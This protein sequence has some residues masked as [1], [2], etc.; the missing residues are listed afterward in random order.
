MISAVAGTFNI[1]HEGHKAMLDRA[2]QLGD[3]VYIG[4]TS[5]RMASSSRDRLNTY[6]I[7]EKAVKEYAASKKKPFSVFTIDDIYGPD[8]MMDHVDVLVV[9]EETLANGKKVVRKASEK[10][11]KMELSVVSIVQ[12]SDGGKLSS[13]DIMNGSCSRNG[14]AEAIDIAVG[15]TNPV[16][17]EAVRNVME[18]IFG[19]VRIFAYDVP[20]G[21][22]EQP[23]GDQTQKGAKNRARAALHDHTLSVG[24]EAGVFEMFD[25]LYDFQYCAILD[26]EGRYTIGTGSGFRYP[27]SVVELVRKGKTVGEAMK[28]VY[29]ET[30]AGK[31]MGAIGILSKGQLD[32]RSLTEQSVLA[33]MIPRIWDEK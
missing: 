5:D 23:F 21:V 9:S 27:D 8:E 3:E 29:G 4:I 7:R 19:Q 15:S 6:Y 33:A 22:P 13:T 12:K 14:D 32:R 16:K 30:N 25:T 31:T 18:R 17:V 1:L 28:I 24:I 10:G 20:S 2:F 26:R 11:K